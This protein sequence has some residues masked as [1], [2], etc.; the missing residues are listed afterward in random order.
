MTTDAKAAVVQ[1]SSTQSST[2]TYV[3]NMWHAVV[4]GVALGPGP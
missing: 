4:D 3:A 1:V 2:R